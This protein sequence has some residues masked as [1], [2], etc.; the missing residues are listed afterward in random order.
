MSAN[1]ALAILH[2][3]RLSALAL[4]LL[5][6]LPVYYASGMSWAGLSSASSWR[7][8]GAFLIDFFPPRVDAEFL[9]FVWRA[10]LETIAVASLG[11]LGAFVI[12]APLALMGSRVMSLSHLGPSRYCVV[13][14]IARVPFRLLA[15]LLRSLP[16]IIWALLFVRIAG[17][18][19]M[20]AILAISLS[21]GGMLAKVYNDIMESGALKP[22]ESLMLAG[23]GRLQ[24]FLYGVL[25]SVSKELISYTVYRWE[26]ALRASVIMGFVGAGGLGQQLELSMRMFQSAEAATLL[27]AFIL[28]VLLA[29]VISALLRW[30]QS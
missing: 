3:R 28:L 18:G 5:I 2:R 14:R 23:A 13:C 27:M 12:G 22:S 7:V 19:P 26:C 8:M 29:D 6:F 15:L 16:E 17:L 20:A 9:H 11:M 25:P 4:A 1:N 21:Y 24:A 10:S 30:S